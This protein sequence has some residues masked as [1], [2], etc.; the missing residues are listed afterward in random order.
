[1]VSESAGLDAPPLARPLAAA[2]A[3][4]C[5]APPVAAEEEAPARGLARVAE[6]GAAG[7]AIMSLGGRVEREMPPATLLALAAKPAPRPPA[8]REEPLPRFSTTM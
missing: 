5:A 4:V 1:M 2:I 3:A 7:E 6:A 8:R